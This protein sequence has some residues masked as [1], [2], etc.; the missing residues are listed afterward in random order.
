MFGDTNFFKDKLD[1]ER[2]VNYSPNSFNLMSLQASPQPSAY[3][4]IYKGS[5]LFIKVLY[6]FLAAISAQSSGFDSEKW[7]DAVT[8][9]QQNVLNEIALDDSDK[10]AKYDTD[11]RKQSFAR[12]EGERRLLEY[13]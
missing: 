5:E 13:L 11:V 7:A 12:G 8:V 2:G 1:K 6:I 3:P 9:F 4:L 10:Y